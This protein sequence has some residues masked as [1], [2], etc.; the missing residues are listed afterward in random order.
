[1]RQNINE[2]ELE[3]VN[4]GTVYISEDR[5]AVAF[6]TIGKAYR[7]KCSFDDAKQYLAQLY[8]DNCHLSEKAFDELVRD[9]FKEKGYI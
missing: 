4:G 1:M 3:K 6:D 8:C 9:K 2:N 7:L 5:N